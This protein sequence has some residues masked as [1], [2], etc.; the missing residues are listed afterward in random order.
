[1]AAITDLAAASSVAAADYLVLSQSGTDK[2]VTADKFAI[3]T[4]GIWTPAVSGDSGSG[5]TYTTQTGIY[6][7]FG[8]WVIATVNITLS[9]KGSLTGTAKF[10][11][12]VTPRASPYIT[13]EAT[14]LVD[15]YS[16]SNAPVGQITS[17]SA[18]VVL[19]KS[20]TTGTHSTIQW[21]ELGN[22]TNM[23]VTAIYPV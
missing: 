7:R 17:S 22:T 15:N 6:V 14:V 16:G 20:G 4:T 23:R 9:S 10:S 13:S 11:L 8:D 12:P 1:M 5:A 19:V 2:K 21:S 3:M 18:F